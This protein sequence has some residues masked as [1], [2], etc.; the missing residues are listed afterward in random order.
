MMKSLVVIN[1]MLFVW[2]NVIGEICVLKRL[3]WL[4]VVVEIICFNSMK[5]IVF[6]ILK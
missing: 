1:V 5:N 6:L 2:F 4:M 3:K